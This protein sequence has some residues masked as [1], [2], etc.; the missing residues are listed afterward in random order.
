MKLPELPISDVLD[1]ITA[2]LNDHHDLLIEAPPGA[3]KTTLVPLV[4]MDQEWLGYRKIIMLEPRRLAAKTAAHRM[5]SLI[6]ESPGQTI[7]Y[8]MRLE[9]RVSKYTK[10]EVVTEGVFARML[11]SDPALQDV[12]L[13]IFDEFHER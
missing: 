4:L 7:G 13:V 9:T 8:R 2:S 5:A 10:V 11:Q 12:G 3:G 6:G 1:D